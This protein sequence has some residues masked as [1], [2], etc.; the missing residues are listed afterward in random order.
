MRWAIAVNGTCTETTFGPLDALDCWRTYLR[1]SDQ[2][3]LKPIA[4]TWG[5]C[6]WPRLCKSCWECVV[7]VEKWEIK[8]LWDTLPQTFG[9]KIDKDSWPDGSEG[10]GS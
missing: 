5:E 3:A 8:D 7:E 2:A 6:H 4:E 1:L 9:L 10:S